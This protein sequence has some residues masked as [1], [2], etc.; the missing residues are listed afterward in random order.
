MIN[1][2]SVCLWF[3]IVCK[4]VLREIAW[5]NTHIFFKKVICWIQNQF[6]TQNFFGLSKLETTYVLSLTIHKLKC[7]LINFERLNYARRFIFI[8]WSLSSYPS[9]KATFP[10]NFYKIFGVFCTYFE[11]RHSSYTSSKCIL[12]REQ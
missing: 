4:L 9:D 6:S 8:C 3:F 11:F 7:K 12:Y 5:L 2:S 1:N 10:L